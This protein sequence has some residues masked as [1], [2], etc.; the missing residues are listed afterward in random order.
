MQNNGKPFSVWLTLLEGF[1]FF[2][3][4]WIILPRLFVGHRVTVS[5]AFFS[6]S[7]DVS[8]RHLIILWVILTIYL[9]TRSTSGKTGRLTWFLHNRSKAFQGLLLFFAVFVIYLNTGLP[10]TVSGDTISAKL[11]PISILAEHDLDLD[12]FYDGIKVEHR[13]SLMQKDNHWYPAYPIFPGLTA[14]P[15][16]AAVSW[17]HPE[18]FDTWRLAYS[19]PEGDLIYHV[20]RWLEHYSAGLIAA[21]S[22]VVVWNVLNL[23]LG[24][25]FFTLWLTLGY[26][27]G[28]SLQSTASWGLWMHGP[29]CLFLALTVYCLYQ[30]QRIF[31]PYALLVAG[32]CAGWAIACRPTNG[33]PI[34]F[35][36]I[37]CIMT[38]RARAWR[39]LVGC[40][41]TLGGAG[42]L[43]YMVYQQIFGGYSSQTSMFS[44]FDPLVLLALLFSPSRG[45]FLF[46]PFLLL[47]T[48]YGCILLKTR[49][50]ELP[51]FCLYGALALC[52]L[53]ACWGPWAGGHSFGPR[54]LSE[55]ALLLI[56]AVPKVPVAI[57]RYFFVR[58]IFMGLVIL[59]C[60]IHLLGTF[61]GDN[62][63]TI[64]QFNGQDYQSFWKF[65]DSQLVWT[66]YGPSDE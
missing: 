53:Y 12:E 28:T 7:S 39:F 43:N 30:K 11:I 40:G 52:L 21:L 47:A 59:A 16:Y 4:A 15:F 35:L 55:V 45:L 14:L 44:Q 10:R 42:V 13:Y 56:L 37:W 29:S 48:V 18:G 24:R 1:L 50:L 34:A 5:L 58:G 23:Q 26:A 6:M 9:I 63:W 60:H 51:A 31:L 57:S 54:L 61:Q 38:Y 25:N 62:D 8:S 20:P 22:V 36:G 46:S 19:V 65:R 32:L 17:L 27:F 2:Q 33:I 49:W 64:K 66:I 3:I 41:I